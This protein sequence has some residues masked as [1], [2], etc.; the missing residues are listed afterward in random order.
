MVTDDKKNIAEISW[1]AQSIADVLTALNTTDR[2][3]SDTEAVKRF[4]TNGPNTLP[5]KKPVSTG[6]IF[7]RQFQS[8]LIYIL[9]LAAIV[10][11]FLGDTADSFII[12]IVLLVNAIVGMFQEGKAQNTLLALTKFTKT[13]ATVLRD[14]VETLISDSEV[15]VGDVLVL[16]EGDKV[17]ADA[18]LI[19]IQAFKVNESALTGESEPVIKSIEPVA[20]T[21]Q[22]PAERT[23]MVYKGTFVVGG[24][25]LAVVVAVGLS[26]QIGLISKKISTIDSEIPLKRNITVLSRVIS[27]GV[28]LISATVFFV[29]VLYGN[30]VRDM[31]FTSVAIAVSLIPEGLPIVITL[32]LATGAYRM[33]KQNALMKTLGAVEALGQATVIAV[34]KTG[35]ITKNELMVEEVFVDHKKF[36]VQG[37][38]YEPKGAI[39]L[40]TAAINPENHPELLFAGKIATMCA[41]ATVSFLEKEGVW[42]V[43]GDPTEAAL[44]VFGEKVGWNKD[45]LDNEEPQ[46][47]EQPFDSKTKY[48]TTLHKGKRKNTQTVVGAPETVL[49]LSKSI[50]SG[51]KTKKMT[52]LMLEQIEAEIRSMSRKGLRVIAF[53]YKSV[54][55]TDGIDVGSAPDLIFGGLYAMRDVLREGVKDSV[56]EAKHNGVRVVMI[57][58]DHK[59]TAE[60]LARDAGIYE[61]GD[62]VVTGNELVDLNDTELLTKL[63][64]TSVFARV[65]PEHKLRIIE[66]FKKRGEVIAMTGDGVNDALSL[67]AADLGIA[68]GKIGT[69]VSKEAADIVLLDDNFK[70][71]VG[72]LEEGR[73]I[74]QTI[75]KVIMYLFSTGFGELFVIV[76]ALLLFLPLPLLPTQILWLNLVTDG[77]LVVAMALEPREKLEGKK[78]VR[79]SKSFFDKTSLFRMFYMSLVMTIGT[80]IVF[81]HFKEIDI[82]RAWT[83]S[84][85]TLAIYQWFNAWNCRSERQSVFSQNPLTN[86]Y[87]I[88]ATVIV[89]VLQLVAIYHPL[90]QKYLHTTSLTFAEL[91]L[92]GAV[93]LTVIL[94]EELR[95]LVWFKPRNI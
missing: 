61:D 32:I 47:A 16:R 93:A 84:L 46:I 80:L 54:P 7:L 85:T 70:S 51:G 12:L 89:F 2:G 94:A 88:L 37:S 45:D 77:F 41:N 63:E 11:Y 75:K 18:R 69:E 13:E 40:E 68:M 55:S 38:G 48:H 90:M 27:V 76:G 8:P 34:D 42:R 72:A 23:C 86:K 71:I 36:S 83:V 81:N 57:T 50:W 73:N 78:F 39:T 62:N 91:I 30:T 31:F 35:T 65:S 60:S 29:G 52:V 87:L 6:V 24:H 56:L 14:G 9:L 58:G 19:E 92:C 53:A 67:V 79:R 1:H 64:K 59:V 95:K 15:V 20:E 10:V 22:N 17:S 5:L 49:D 28:L 43:T 74:Y 21:I 25:A 82:V 26:T 66:L 3:L 44:L 4:R 33:A